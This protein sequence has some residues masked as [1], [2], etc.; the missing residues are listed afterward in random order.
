[1]SHIMYMDIISCVQGAMSGPSSLT[2]Q[3]RAMKLFI[4]TQIP[5]EIVLPQSLADMITYR[6][7]G[8]LH[9]T[10][11]HVHDKNIKYP[12]IHNY[13]PIVNSVVGN[14]NYYYYCF[15]TFP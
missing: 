10:N 14:T 13:L 4:H 11:V 2:V 8:N 6:P 9:W 15:Y 5:Q 7:D 3:A 12:K 1:M